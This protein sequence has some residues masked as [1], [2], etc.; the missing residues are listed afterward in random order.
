MQIERAVRPGIFRNNRTTFRGP[1]EVFH[2]HLR[3]SV[4]AGGWR[5][6]FVPPF[7]MFVGERCSRAVAF[8]LFLLLLSFR[9]ESVENSSLKSVLM[10]SNKTAT[11]CCYCHSDWKLLSLLDFWFTRAMRLQ[12]RLCG[13]KAFPSNPECFRNFQPEV[14]PKWKAPLVALPPGLQP[15]TG[16]NT[17]TAIPRK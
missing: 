5:L 4:S 12:T 7:P 1:S 13:W 14:L 3:N 16:Q 11:N 9:M 2:F 17:F 15:V 8:F 10:S 6:E